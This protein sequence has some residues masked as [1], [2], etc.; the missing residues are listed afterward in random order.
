MLGVEAVFAH[1]GASALEVLSTG[2]IDLVI[3]DI[4][5]PGM[6][7]LEVIRQYKLRMEAASRVPVVVVTG[8]VTAEIQEECTKLGVD[9]FLTKPVQVEKLRN[10]IMNHVSAP[11]RACVM[12]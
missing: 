7:G 12:S 8:D 3:L 10:V 1:S 4:Q 2:G 11:Q 5:M 9:S 6:S